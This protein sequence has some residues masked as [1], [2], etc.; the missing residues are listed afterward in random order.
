MKRLNR[1]TFLK[2]SGSAAAGALLTACAPGA[3]LPPGPSGGV[4]GEATPAPT[5]PPAPLPSATTAPAATAT[6]PEPTPTLLPAPRTYYR[7][8]L[9]KFFPAVKSK[10]VQASDA[11]VWQG[12][13]VDP[14]VVR[15][16]LDK[17]ITALTGLAD[18]KAAWQALFKPTEKIA[19]KVNVFRNSTIW[20]H[21]EL[22]KAVTDSLQEAG[23]PGE[24]ITIFD[25][26]TSELEEAKYP[27]NKDGPGVRCHG[28]DDKYAASWV[29]PGTDFKLSD[30]LTNC[31]ALINMPVLKSHMI[32]GFTFALKNHYGSVSYPDGL[33]D[34][35]NSLPPLNAIPPIRETTRLVIGDVLH[36]NT[37]YSNS[38]PY[39][40]ADIRSDSILMSY[41]PL[42][43]DLVGLEL[44]K[45][46]AEQKGSP[47]DGIL[48]MAERWIETAGQAGLGAGDLKD[49]ELVRV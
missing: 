49:I 7:P 37:K 15:K 11:A 31:D 35:K 14:A 21:V 3:P 42:A 13:A 25:F 17:S 27:V 12:E 33:H 32:A 2:L 4:S 10:V 46:L 20:T 36:A 6:Q 16:L 43:H 29:L 24:Q 45:K 5:E 18:A 41:D 22:V 28:S 40:E 38:F 19:I 1:R 9:I 39:W 8:E 34:I 44:L 26:L 23:I 48:G 47:M 30:I